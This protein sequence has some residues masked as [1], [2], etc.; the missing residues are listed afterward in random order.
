MP[1][2]IAHALRYLQAHR[3]DN[4][5]WPERIIENPQNFG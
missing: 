4:D 1:A 3:W 2:A 5:S